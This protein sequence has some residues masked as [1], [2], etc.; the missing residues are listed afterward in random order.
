[1][2]GPVGGYL[3]CGTGGGDQWASLGVRIGRVTSG[4]QVPDMMPARLLAALRYTTAV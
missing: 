4:G 2:P 1:M 3:V